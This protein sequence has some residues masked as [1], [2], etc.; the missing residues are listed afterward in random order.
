MNRWLKWTLRILLSAIA[1]YLI[2]RKISWPETWRLLL[3]SDV[4]WLIP[5]L[6]LYNASQFVSA[7]RLLYF[8][9]ILAIP[10]PWISNLILY[11]KGMFYNLFLPGGIGGDG[12]KVHFLYKHYQAPVKRLITATLL[13]RLNGL[14]ILGLLVVLLAGG[15]LLPEDVLFFPAWWLIPAYVFVMVVCV[16]LLRHFLPAYSPVIL[17]TTLLSAGIQALQLISVLCLLETMHVDGSWL[18]YLLLF[19]ASSVAA[20]IPFT[21][22]GAGARELVFMAVAPL[23]GIVP[24]Q[25]VAVSLLFFLLTAVSSLAG[26]LIN[27]DGRG[28]Y[29]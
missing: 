2:F 17:G 21:I 15:G 7:R 20:V 16:W 23:L 1:L 18:A 27:P 28:T 29:S 4:L 14:V 11:Y 19:L 13:D 12:Y 5:A 8:Y 22:G 26:V 24:E 6:V 3:S 25:A 10:I 9:R